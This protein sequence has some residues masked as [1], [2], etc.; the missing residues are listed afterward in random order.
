M[1]EDITLRWFNYHKEQWIYLLGQALSLT[2]RHT[3]MKGNNSHY[4]DYI[5]TQ[6]NTYGRTF[7]VGDL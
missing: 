2:H 4:K 6:L 7:E 5:L 1:T 3:K